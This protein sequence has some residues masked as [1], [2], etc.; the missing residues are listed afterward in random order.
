MSEVTTKLTPIL[1]GWAGFGVEVSC[2]G[3]TASATNEREALEK[4]YL[5]L[6]IKALAQSK[7]EC[8]D[9]CADDCLEGIPTYCYFMVG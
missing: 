4:L 8:A 2:D 3:E 5:K 7:G 1:G 9:R 6:K